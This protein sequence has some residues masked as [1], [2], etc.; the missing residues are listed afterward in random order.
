MLFIKII[1]IIVLYKV[2]SHPLSYLSLQQLS[3][4][5]RAGDGLLCFPDEETIWLWD[6]FNQA[7]IQ[8]PCQF[9]VLAMCMCG[10]SYPISAH[11]NFKSTHRNTKFVWFS[12]AV[13]WGGMSSPSTWCQLSLCSMFSDTSEVFVFTFLRCWYSCIV[14]DRELYQYYFPSRNTSTFIALPWASEMAPWLNI[15]DVHIWWP[16]FYAQRTHKCGRRESILQLVLT[17]FAQ[18]QPLHQTPV[19]LP[20]PT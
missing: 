18:C 17:A 5:G 9:A 20:H 10:C 14:C 15:F 19:M 1:I 8:C 13:L 16:G 7:P 11:H 6:P 3:C 2:C 12:V 4:W